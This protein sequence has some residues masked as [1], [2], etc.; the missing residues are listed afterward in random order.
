MHELFEFVSDKIGVTQL[1]EEVY[2][3]QAANVQLQEKLQSNVE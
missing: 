2:Q 3:L 1:K